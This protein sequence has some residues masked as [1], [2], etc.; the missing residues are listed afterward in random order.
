M[1]GGMLTP[2]EVGQLG[3]VLQ[4]DNDKIQEFL[5]K[6]FPDQVAQ[7]A[8]DKLKA[9]AAPEENA[10]QYTIVSEG[11]LWVEFK[12]GGKKYR[13][14]REPFKRGPGRP[15][16]NPWI[17][18][19]AVDRITDSAVRA[20]FYAVAAYKLRKEGAEFATNV[21]RQILAE[22]RKTL[23]KGNDGLI[24]LSH[25]TK[26]SVAAMQAYKSKP[27]PQGVRLDGI[28]LQ[29][30]LRAVSAPIGLELEREL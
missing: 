29:A 15:R 4:Y 27:T 3:E 16:A 23:F 24:A 25:L 5:R 28:V 20:A 17:D 1:T 19:R 30:L 2:D 7:E 8:E 6:F 9:G 13:S 18:Q 26:V 21:E 12:V 10:A 11:D 22:V 14:D